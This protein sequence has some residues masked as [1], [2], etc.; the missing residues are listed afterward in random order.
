MK[1][2]QA[3]SQVRWCSFLE[4]SVLK[5]I[6]VLVLRVV[7]LGK[8]DNPDFLFIPV[9]APQVPSGKQVALSIYINKIILLGETC[10]YIMLSQDV[11]TIRS[12][13]L[14]VKHGHLN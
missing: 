7:E 14:A 3:I 4:T 1:F 2:S 10:I 13:S 6:F 12:F 8:V 11:D 5:T 9:K